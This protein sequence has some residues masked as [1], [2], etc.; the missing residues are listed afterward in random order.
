MPTPPTAQPTAS[1]RSSG[2]PPTKAQL[3]F[4]RDLATQRGETFAVPRTTAEASREI[5]RLKS[6]RRTSASDLR[7]ER[8]QISDDM[9]TRRGDDA[10]VRDS[11]VTGYGS[12][13]TW[14]RD[15]SSSESPSPGGEPE[16]AAEPPKATNPPVVLARYRTTGDGER[17]IMGQR[18]LGVVRVT[19][20]PTVGDGRRYVIERKLTSNAELTALVADYMSLAV[21]HDT[22]P[23]LG[24]YL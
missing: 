2:P 17:T 21:E 22:I 24:K 23:I 8:R 13:A 1:R 16:A 5:E 4:L 7:R 3:K 14:N 9:A 12:S 15:T 20:V 18:V 6:R 11:E 19:D 10:R